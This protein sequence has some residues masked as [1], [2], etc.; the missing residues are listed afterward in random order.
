[1]LIWVNIRNIMCQK[2]IETTEHLCRDRIDSPGRILELDGCKNCGIIQKTQYLGKSTKRD[3][4]PDCI[5]K[6]T[7][8]KIDGKWKKA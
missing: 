7:W 5:A 4:C 6:G 1:M 3:P 8:V 2:L